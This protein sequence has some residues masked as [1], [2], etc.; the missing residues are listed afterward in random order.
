MGMVR[1]PVKQQVWVA[2]KTARKHIKASLEK[3][4]GYGFWSLRSRMEMIRLPIKNIQ[5]SSAQN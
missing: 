4:L 1:F 2:R 3:A 5:F